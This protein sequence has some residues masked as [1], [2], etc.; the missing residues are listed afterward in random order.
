M[1]NRK[2]IWSRL[3][4]ANQ[5]SVPD[6]MGQSDADLKQ[7]AEDLI[8]RGDV[9]AL[10]QLLCDLRNSKQTLS[11]DVN[12][13][14]LTGLFN[15]K[16]FHVLLQHEVDRV[17]RHGGALAM[18]YIDLND[19]KGIND[20][21]GH[22]AGDAALIEV[23]KLLKTHSRTS[24]VAVRLSGDEFAILFVEASADEAQMATDRLR[25][26]FSALH[27]NW[28]E[29]NIPVGASVGVASFTPEMN[30]STFIIA[31]DD[32]MYRE[33]QKKNVSRATG[34]SQRA[35]AVI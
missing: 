9:N 7:L 19:F 3:I 5:S 6:V 29:N 8:N 23:G 31:A 2:E 14:S 25:D 4:P 12:I 11:Y 16:A 32:A 26:E 33:K 13:D 21:Y 15:K 10:A 1:L 17:Q 27:I 35:L 22:G 18:A 24:D 28:N 30:A 34:Q 20:T